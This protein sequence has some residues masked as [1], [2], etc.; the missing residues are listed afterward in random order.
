MKIIIVG[1]GSSG[2]MTAS[3][4]N[5]FIPNSDITVLESPSVPRIGV[6]ESV[7]IHIKE[8]LRVL[9]IDETQFMFETGSVYKYGNNF[10]NWFEGKGEWENFTFGWNKS[11]EQLLRSPYHGV[12]WDDHRAV[13]ADGIRFTDYW[14]ELFDKGQ[15]DRSF[16][17]SYTCWHH[18][19]EPNL[20][21]Y[22]GN[23]PFLPPEDLAWAYHINTEKFADYLHTRVAVPRGVK[24]KIAH[25][26]SVNTNNDKIEKLIL[27]SGE[28]MTADLYVDCSGFH[29]VLINKFENEWKW[30]NDWPGDSA[31][32]C[33]LDY[34][35]PAVEMVNYTKSIAMD[36]GWVFDISLYHRRGTGYIF[37]NDFVSDD[38]V[39]KEYAEK[40]LTKPKF[41]PKKLKWDKKRMRKPGFGNV[42]AIGMTA[43]FVE[44]MEAN[45]LGVISNCAWELTH[46]LEAHNFN[47]SN[48]D[49]ATY[50][51]RVGYTFDDV[52]DFILVH[53]TLSSRTDTPFWNEMRSIGEKLNHKQLI[54]DKYLDPKNT[55]DGASRAEGF[56][57]DFMWLELAAAW[58]LDLS[59]WP[60]K[61][62]DPDEVALAKAHFEYL[63]LNSKVASKQFQNNYEFLKKYR[64]NNMSSAEW[65]DKKL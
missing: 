63:N 25:I 61:Q 22:I 55:I 8:F 24:S 54:I 2:W 5:K 57:P 34:I 31:Y 28:E 58:H 4:L 17:H 48:I 49:W 7:T 44:P 32:V 9:D 30:Y 53:Y 64:F 23:E 3:W 37:S 40:I 42:V 65:L 27:E 39:L 33:Q 56:F 62:V 21:P 10:I 1:G 38:D 15:V 36:Y 29:R 41:T 12:N 14:L 20:A 46:T 6:G 16:T 19:T 47:T 35:D 11:R 50:N 13:S 26:S 18:F 59:N 43:G 60:R 52:A 51:D 45:M